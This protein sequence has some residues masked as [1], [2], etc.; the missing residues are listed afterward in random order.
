[1]VGYLK[2]FWIDFVMVWRVVVEKKDEV[3]VWYRILIQM[4]ADSDFSDAIIKDRFIRYCRRDKTEWRLSRL[5]D[6]IIS[7]R[8]QLLADLERTFRGQS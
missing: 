4:I 5:I 2:L 7:H 8:P 3:D 6:S 1:M